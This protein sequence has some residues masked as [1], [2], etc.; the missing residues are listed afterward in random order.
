MVR[1]EPRLKF[2]TYLFAACFALVGTI[3]LTGCGGCGFGYSGKS[4]YDQ[5]VEGQKAAIDGLT[6]KGGKA[7]LKKYPQGDAYS[8][9]LSGVTIDDEVIEL[10]EKAAPVSE[11][12][13]SGSTVTDA[14]AARINAEKIG[15]FLL[16]LNLSKTQFSDAGLAELKHLP[17]LMQLDVTG[18][19]VTKDAATKFQKARR[20]S[21]GAFFKQLNLKI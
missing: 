15:S 17:M 16:V 13:L 11:L 6:A 10:I 3:S 9:N 19:K 14:H 18:S 12:N 21:P 4:E 20:E 5:L 7:E 2:P 8:L 1:S